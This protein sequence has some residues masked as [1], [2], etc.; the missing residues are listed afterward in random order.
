MIDAISHA[1]DTVFSLKIVFGSFFLCKFISLTRFSGSWPNAR[2]AHFILWG[3]G[4]SSLS[5]FQQ[6]N[7]NACLPNERIMHRWKNKLIIFPIIVIS[8]WDE[9]KPHTGINK[10]EN[11]SICS[12]WI[13]DNDLWRLVR[14]YAGV[15]TQ[16]RTAYCPH[17]QMDRLCGI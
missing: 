4:Q 2:L 6:T 13:R 15:S 7:L 8:S 3:C 16:R 5:T 17:N 9:H 14:C 12:S 1:F 11:E 10:E